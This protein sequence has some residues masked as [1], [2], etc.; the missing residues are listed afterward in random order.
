MPADRRPT[1]RRLQARTASAQSMRSLPTG[2]PASRRASPWQQARPRVDPG[3][4]R[5]SRPFPPGNAAAPP[6]RR[7]PCRRRWPRQR[8][9]SREKPVGRRIRS[10]T[11]RFRMPADLSRPDPRVR[12]SRIGAAG[13]PASSQ[14][15]R[16]SRQAAQRPSAAS[17][18][19][20]AIQSLPRRWAS[21]RAPRSRRPGRCHRLAAGR[22]RVHRSR[23]APVTG[24]SRN[25]SAKARSVGACAARR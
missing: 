8:S 4:R 22:R 5:C 13:L 17:S 9:G 25:R 1:P 24:G 15:P 10:A 6:L 20:T 18:P 7:L 2:C 16:V 3:S 12:P 14:L 23:R 21:A 11:G 19:R